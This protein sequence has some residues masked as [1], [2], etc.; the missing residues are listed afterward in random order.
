MTTVSHS[1]EFLGVKMDVDVQYTTWRDEDIIKV[2]KEVI[3]YT[4]I[5]YMGK[6][7]PNTY[8]AHNKLSK[9]LG[10]WGIDFHG[11]VN[12]AVE[13]VDDS[14]FRIFLSNIFVER[15]TELEKLKLRF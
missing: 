3:E 2:D 14:K 7:I 5:N 12:K 9:Q 11:E 10:E 6:D 1:I 4:R 8:D 13:K 15:V